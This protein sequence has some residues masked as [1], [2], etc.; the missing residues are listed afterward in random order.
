[1]G[2][3]TNFARRRR[4]V[5]VE[6]ALIIQILDFGLRIVKIQNLNYKCPNSKF[7]N[8]KNEKRE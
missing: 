8:F 3:G 2:D 1:M 4:Y 5:V 7:Q 6:N